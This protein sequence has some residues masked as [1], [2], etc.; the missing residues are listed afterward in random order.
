LREVRR[1]RRKEGEREENGKG[2]EDSSNICGIICT[3]NIYTQT[4]AS[5]IYA[6]PPPPREGRNKK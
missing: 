6:R 2:R 5:P 3:Y 4:H 1:E